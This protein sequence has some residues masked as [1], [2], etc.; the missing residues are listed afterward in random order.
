MQRNYGEKTELR[1]RG[2]NIIVIIVLQA[3]VR[4]FLALIAVLDDCHLLIFGSDCTHLEDRKSFVM[5]LW[6]LAFGEEPD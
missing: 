3:F 1:Y 5:V 4:I 2:V 6:N